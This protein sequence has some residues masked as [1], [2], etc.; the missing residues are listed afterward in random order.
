MCACPKPAPGF[1]ST[2]YVIFVFNDLKWEVVVRFVDTSGI[3]VIA[4]DT[5]FPQYSFNVPNSKY[6][7]LRIYHIKHAAIEYIYFLLVRIFRSVV[8]SLR[9]R[10]I[11]AL[12]VTSLHY[13]DNNSAVS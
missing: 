9:W 6:L 10:T 2:N 5:F 8:V 12:S 4:V 11:E 13:I 3:N 1:P 7:R